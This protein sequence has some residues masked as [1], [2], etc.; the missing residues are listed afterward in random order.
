MLR[1]TVVF[2]N[3]FSFRRCLCLGAS[4][5]L[6]DSMMNLID[7]LLLWLSGVGC[8]L[9]SNGS[10]CSLGVQRHPQSLVIGLL[11]G[12]Q[13]LPLVAWCTLAF[14]LSPREICPMLKYHHLRLFRH[15]GTCV[16]RK[17]SM[18]SAVSIFSTLS[19]LPRMVCTGSIWC[20]GNGQSTHQA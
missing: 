14:S 4:L 1:S 15:V 11:V 9:A 17:H 19:A 2:S 3:C 7:C 20:C 12:I 5:S 18:L 10:H 6:C 13:R 8:S 16:T